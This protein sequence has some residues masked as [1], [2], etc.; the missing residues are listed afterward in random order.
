MRPLLR[1]LLFAGGVIGSLVVL[2]LGVFAL[3][4][5]PC[6]YRLIYDRPSPSERYVAELYSRDC[7]IGF[8]YMV[9]L[10]DRSAVPLPSIFGVPP[11]TVAA[12][13]FDILNRRNDIF[14]E[15]E[16]KL[17]I[18]HHGH[19]NLDRTEWGGVRLEVREPPPQP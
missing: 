9:M 7:G 17:V 10:R 15:G 2:A 18:Q 13:D 6:D 4:Y 8:F 1:T 5:T 12:S 16:G 11:G 19:V 3:A 14:W